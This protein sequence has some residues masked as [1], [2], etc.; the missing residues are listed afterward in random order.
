MTDGALCDWI[1]A[2]QTI[3]LLALE[4]SGHVNNEPV[5]TEW[6][7]V[8]PNLQESQYLHYLTERQYIE[9]KRMDPDSLIIL[10]N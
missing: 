5:I 6:H 8:L 1:L 4:N 9:R 3:E 7:P 2:E 10:I